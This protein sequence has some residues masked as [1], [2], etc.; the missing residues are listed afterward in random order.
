MEIIELAYRVS[1]EDVERACNAKSEELA[2][3]YKARK[4]SGREVKQLRSIHD[5]ATPEEL[6]RLPRQKRIALGIEEPR[7]VDVPARLRELQQQAEDLKGK[8]A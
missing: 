7:E 5:P 8:S 2:A 3:A 4:L 1:L 6:G